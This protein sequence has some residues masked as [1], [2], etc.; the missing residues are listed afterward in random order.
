[1]AITYFV[2]FISAN[3]L[4]C[5]PNSHR[6]PHLN[7]LRLLDVCLGL[8]SDCENYFGLLLDEFSELVH[9]T[10]WLGCKHIIIISKNIEYSLKIY[11]RFSVGIQWTQR[12]VRYD[13]RGIYQVTENH[14]SFWNRSTFLKKHL[15]LSTSLKNLSV[16]ILEQLFTAGHIATAYFICSV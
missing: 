13:Q 2:M 14:H 5:L 3:G 9:G 12:S 15:V 11:M 8:P 7:L 10:K 1:M 16:E 6:K 4:K